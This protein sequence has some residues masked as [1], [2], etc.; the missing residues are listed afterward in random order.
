MDLTSSHHRSFQKV[1]QDHDIAKY[2]KLNHRV[3]RAAWNEKTSQWYITIRIND[4]PT[5]D[6]EDSC[7]YFI[8]GSGILN[9]WKVRA[10]VPL[11]G[12]AAGTDIARSPAFAVP[13][14]PRTSLL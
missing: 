1:V 10:L 3:I 9:A 13:G 11:P 2:F 7:D 14:R 12:F 5:T 6:F 4:D 8:N